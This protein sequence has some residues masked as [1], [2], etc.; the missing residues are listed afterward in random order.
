[1]ATRDKR[2]SLS[3][4]YVSGIDCD[5]WSATQTVE[6][7]IACPDPWLYSTTAKVYDPASAS[8]WTVKNEGEEVGFVAQV[9]ISGYVRI[10]G[11]DS[12]MAWDASADIPASTVLTLD[13]REG[14]RDLYYMDGTTRVSCLGYI[15]EWHWPQMPH[16]TTEGYV[17]STAVNGTLTLTE[18]RGAI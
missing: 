5:I 17:R 10:A 14:H 9:K 12:K 7:S 18:R 2:V 15:T 16:T 4:T 1:M 11:E 6:V 3:G 13:T 8:Q